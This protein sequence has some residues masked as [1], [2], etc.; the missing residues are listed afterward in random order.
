MTANARIGDREKCIHA[1]MNDYISKP[2]QLAELDAALR[3]ATGGRPSPSSF[4]SNIPKTP[5]PKADDSA[6]DASVLAGLRQLGQP[7]QPDPVAE[8]IG[9]FVDDGDQ[10]LGK[11]EAALKQND[12]SA[13]SPLAHGLKGSA[14]NLGARPLAALAAQLEDAASGARLAAVE[15]LLTRLKKEYKRVRVQL[16][17]ETNR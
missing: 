17:K 10:R 6:L 3:Q 7:N 5:A 8:L 13:I 1:G 4:R 2:V 16:E 9:L 11:M 14:S 12:L 15:E